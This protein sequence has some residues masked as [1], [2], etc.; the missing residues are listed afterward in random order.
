VIPR[1]TTA[2]RHA[3]RRRTRRLVHFI[4]RIRQARVLRASAQPIGMVAGAIVAHPAEWRRP[5][6]FAHAAHV[7]ARVRARP[8]ASA[9]RQHA[10]QIRHAEPILFMGTRAAFAHD[11]PILHRALRLVG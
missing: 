1:I 7:I 3:I 6:R 9:C 2:Y 11:H 10:G 5:A 4:A 8:V